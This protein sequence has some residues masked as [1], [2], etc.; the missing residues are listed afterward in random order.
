ML[1]LGGISQR[2]LESL[3]AC[4]VVTVD[5]AQKA[6]ERWLTSGM[7]TEEVDLCSDL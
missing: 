4:E 2:R 6:G 1:G 3:E 7:P 5:M